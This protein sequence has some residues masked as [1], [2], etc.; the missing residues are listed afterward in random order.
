MAT[1][2]RFETL[3]LELYPFIFEHLD[4]YDVLT[5]RSVSKRLA[6]LVS[7]YRPL[8]LTVHQQRIDLSMSPRFTI[9][10][11]VGPKENYYHLNRPANFLNMVN[12]QHI[13][14]PFSHLID[15]SVLR[16]LQF[17]IFGELAER[18]KPDLV[19]LNRFNRLEYLDFQLRT[20]RYSAN[21]DYVLSFPSLTV[22][23]FD[24]AR[25]ASNQPLQDLRS[26]QFD[27]PRLVALSC[28]YEFGN[29][30]KFRHPLTVT[31]LS[32]LIFNQRFEI[33]QNLE[34]LQFN[35]LGR[36]YCRTILSSFPRLHVI[37]SISPF[38]GRDDLEIILA[39]RRNLRRN[40]LQIYARNIQLVA[41]NDPN[42]AEPYRVIPQ[43]FAIH[44]S[45]APFYVQNFD[46]LDDF[47]R[48][49]GEIIDYAA[50]MRVAPNGLP[51]QFF[52][53]FTG[54]K[55]ITTAGPVPDRNVLLHFIKSCKILVALRLD[56]CDFDQAFFEQLPLVNSLFALKVLECRTTQ[57]DYTFLGR[58]KQLRSFVTD[59]DVPMREALA[60]D[61]LK[62]LRKFEF[63]KIR[64]VFQIRRTEIATEVGNPVYFHLQTRSRD[65]VFPQITFAGLI[66]WLANL[67]RPIQTRSKRPRTQ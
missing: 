66:R 20:F 33:F 4:L 7:F 54:I 47:L 18:F 13:F 55:F 60:L 22:L 35:E 56:N 36:S 51:P 2:S 58:M 52:T 6:Q 21:T 29:R 65:I 49:E 12:G 62:H 14:L 53:K 5:M 48:N 16:Y 64:Q 31:H 30:V 46:Q 19:Q 8:E 17:Q 15:F 27:T 28:D 1:Q 45:L 34:Q 57:L 41:V 3:P 42:L 26:L 37:R 25:I 23:K 9:F 10:G 11:S 63:M 43:Q 32:T 24:A 67:Q 50:L 38:L 61:T 39:I 59:Q 40:D 44:L